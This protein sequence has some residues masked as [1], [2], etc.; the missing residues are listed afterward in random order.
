M[1]LTR[2][3]KSPYYHLVFIDE[4]GTRKKVSTR[5]T[6]RREAEKFMRKYPD[7]ADILC[8]ND[9]CNPGQITKQPEPEPQPEVLAPKLT[10]QQFKEEYTTYLEGSKS[11]NYL[12]SV[13]LSFKMLERETGNVLLN[14]LNVRL[15]DKFISK[16]YARSP[17]SAALYYKTL[18]AAFSKAEVWGYLES[19]VLKKIKAPRQTIKKPHFITR[20]DLDAI[21][22]ST[23][24]Q[25]LKDIFVFAFMTGMRLGEVL[26]T[27]WDAIDMTNKIVTAKNT[28]EF[29]TKSKK[30]RIIP[31][32][33]DCYAVIERRSKNKKKGNNYLFTNKKNQ[34]FKENFVSK[35][36][37]EAVRAAKLGEE[38]HF[39][40][41]R[42]SFASILVQNGVSIYVVK[43][44][45]GHEDIKT[46]E[47]Y[48]H[49]QN[50][51]LVKAVTVFDQ[52]ILKTA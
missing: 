2:E 49:L 15:M 40:T 50:E 51:S 17:Y 1:Y 24:D 19:N 6:V 16:T 18:K 5:Q 41:L 23:D 7:V 25:T 33:E 34:K 8:P 3:S 22:K 12:C 52:K 36:F 27:S 44:L 48:A 29:S 11:K 43:E 4:S 39:H 20:E 26:N 14:L 30:D 13:K 10:L 47:I 45:L 42:H 37:K 31:M 38:T 9:K 21:L 32:S 35:E 46:T 28:N